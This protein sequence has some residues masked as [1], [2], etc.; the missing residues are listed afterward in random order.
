MIIDNKEYNISEKFN[1]KRY[2]KDKIIIKLKGIQNITNMSDMFCD[3][4]S[5]ISLPDT[6]KLYTSNVNNMSRIFSCCLSLSSLP[7]ISK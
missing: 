5:L 1:I 6:S 7:D 4:A 3:C 2:N